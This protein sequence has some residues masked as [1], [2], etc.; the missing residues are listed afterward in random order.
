TISHL[1]SHACHAVRAREETGY[2]GARKEIMRRRPRAAP[3]RP[4]DLIDFRLLVGILD[5]GSV[6]RGAER[7]FLSLPA[8]SNRVKHL[9]A[10]LTV[11]LCPRGGR[12]MTPTRAGQAVGRHARAI[13]KQLESLRQEV[14]EFAT[15]GKGCVRVHGSTSF[16]SSFLPDILGDYLAG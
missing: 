4:M 11:I 16:V 15:G 9:E 14:G 8:A 13:L 7:A 3:R 10:E 1:K 12:G 5:S 2:A 6:T